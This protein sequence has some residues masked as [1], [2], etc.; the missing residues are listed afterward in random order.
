[1]SQT[2]SIAEERAPPTHMRNNSTKCGRAGNTCGS[3]LPE[4][5]GAQVLHYSGSARV[6]LP[7]QEKR[8]RPPSGDAWNRANIWPLHSLE[9]DPPRH[10]PYMSGPGLACASLATAACTSGGSSQSA[11][12]ARPAPPRGQSAKACQIRAGAPLRRRDGERG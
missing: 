1:M 12:P 4:R 6:W 10:D 3:I 9:G 7:L 2:R 11:E 8:S 5:P